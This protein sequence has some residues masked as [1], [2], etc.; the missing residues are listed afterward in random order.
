MRS[1]APTRR[2]LTE[3]P[4]SATLSKVPVFMVE[5]THWVP[6]SARTREEAEN[7]AASEPNLGAHDC[8]PEVIAH[9]FEDGGGALH[10]SDHEEIVP[11]GEGQ[12]RTIRQIL[13][14]DRRA[15]SIVRDFGPALE[16]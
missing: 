7:L 2:A 1:I 13:E 8:M 10:F 6:V 4:T 3:P 12:G 5:I 11:I 9:D 14:A 16:D 15:A